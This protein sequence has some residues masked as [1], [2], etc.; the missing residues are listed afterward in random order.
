[1]FDHSVD[2]MKRSRN[3]WSADMMRV[4]VDSLSGLGVG[5]STK[6]MPCRSAEPAQDL[7]ISHHDVS[8]TQKP[9]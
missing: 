6:N 1:M 9:P 2:R 8:W 7:F 4:E 3:V 5:R